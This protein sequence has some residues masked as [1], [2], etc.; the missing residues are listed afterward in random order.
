MYGNRWQYLLGLYR[1]TGDNHVYYANTEAIADTIDALDTSKCTDS[2]LILPQGTSGAATE[3]YINTLGIKTGILS[4]PP[5]CLTTG[6]DSSNPIGDYF[7]APTLAT[8]NTVC[9]V[10]SSAGYGPLVGSACAYWNDTASVS[11]WDGAARP[12]LKH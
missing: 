12:I 6:G 5:I 4:S 9:M 10:G 1:H 2:G 3:G 11:W 7:Y 8:G